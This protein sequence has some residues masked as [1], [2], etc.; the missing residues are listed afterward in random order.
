MHLRLRRIKRVCP[1]PTLGRVPTILNVG[2][3]GSSSSPAATPTGHAPD[4][5]NYPPTRRRISMSGRSGAGLLPEASWRFSDK[6]EGWWRK[7]CWHRNNGAA[8]EFKGFDARS[9]WRDNAAPLEIGN[10][11]PFL[12]RHKDNPCPRLFTAL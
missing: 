8:D 9:L 11:P 3:R 7:T 6:G 4:S 10:Y 2:S 5:P 1:N 12:P